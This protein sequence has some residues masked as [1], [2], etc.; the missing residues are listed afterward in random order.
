MIVIQRYARD[1]LLV[2]GAIVAADAAGV[3]PVAFDSTKFCAEW[4]KAYDDKC[5]AANV[6]CNAIPDDYCPLSN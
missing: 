3:A 6:T 2:S 4:R 1:G 5:Q